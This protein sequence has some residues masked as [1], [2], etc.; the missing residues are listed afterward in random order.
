MAERKSDLS[1]YIKRA[2]IGLLLALAA[3][4]WLRFD[5]MYNS[6][7]PDESRY[8]YTGRLLLSGG[9]PEDYDLPVSSQLPAY[10][11]GLGDA[12]GGLRGG[13]VAALLL[14]FLSIFLFYKLCRSFL[15]DETAAFFSAFIFALQAPHIF[16]SK[17]ATNDIISLCLFIPAVWIGIEAFRAEGARTSK[18]VLAAVL[19]VAAVLCNY[20]LLIYLPVFIAFAFIMDRKKA[21][22]Y[23]GITVALIAIYFVFNISDFGNFMDYAFP[24]ASLGERNILKVLVLVFEYML[25]PL[26]LFFIAGD[27]ENRLVPGNRAMIVI[28]ALALPFVLFHIATA[29]LTAC[30]RNI[31]FALVF[32]LIPSGAV[33][34]DFLRKNMSYYAS[35]VILMIALGCIAFYENS[36]LELAYPN[37]KNMM[38]YMSFELTKTATILS[39]DPYLVRYH[40]YPQIKGD[41]F[42]RTDRYMGLKGDAAINQILMDV[43]NGK[44]SYIVVNGLENPKLARKMRRGVTKELYRLPYSE[45][46]INTKI[47]N[48][49]NL[50]SFDLYKRKY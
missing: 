27:F 2:L 25:L 13:R 34:K 16:L 38:K 37:S 40:F 49:I 7:Q 36:R 8:L 28:A 29:S 10:I 41:R 32:L 12:A 22:I 21:L 18:N 47:M 14:G 43:K 4:A 17:T 31:S 15:R 24:A 46:F 6:P 48:Y 23:T 1:F 33:V 9:S 44:F 20:Y 5:L 45:D 30:W 50:G 19:F 3:M 42:F 35:T 39:E 26:V 11:I